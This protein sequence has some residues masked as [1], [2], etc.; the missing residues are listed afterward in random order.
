MTLQR[1]I[2]IWG[3]VLVLGVAFL[4]ILLS[5]YF[6]RPL[7]KL[8]AG[9]N[10]LNDGDTDVDINIQN[11]DEFGDLVSTFNSMTRNLRSQAKTIERKT[12]ENNKLLGNLLP[13]QVVERF[14]N[15][16]HIADQH[17]QTTVMHLE[18][19]GFGEI[20]TSLGASNA[21]IKLQG[22]LD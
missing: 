7:E 8:T 16:E 20:S 5:S 9:V 4:A 11:N 14:R 6:V 18:L 1:N 13:E 19:D 22:I 10:A 3:V 21:A 12:E 2:L 15:G 17:Q